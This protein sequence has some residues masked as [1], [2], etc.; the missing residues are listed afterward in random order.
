VR[1]LS[2]GR[3]LDAYASSADDHGVVTRAAQDDDSQRWLIELA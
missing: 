2:N 3:L 1:Q